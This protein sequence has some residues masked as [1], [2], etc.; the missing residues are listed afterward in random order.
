[1]RFF[2]PQGWPGSGTASLKD[3][4]LTSGFPLSQQAAPVAA[5]VSGPAGAAANA[6]SLVPDSLCNAYPAQPPSVG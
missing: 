6:N 3:Q 1:M 4:V 5:P 2:L